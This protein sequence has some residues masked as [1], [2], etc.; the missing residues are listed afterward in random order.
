M[1]LVSSTG[2]LC[3]EY[4]IINTLYASEVDHVEEQLSNSQVVKIQP[5]SIYLKL[6]LLL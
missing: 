2:Q 1:E 3:Y 5:K 6:L 4:R